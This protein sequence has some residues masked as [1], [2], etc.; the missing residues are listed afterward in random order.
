MSKYIILLVSILILSFP[1]FAA[2][3]IRINIAPKDIEYH[4]VNPSGLIT[5]YTPNGILNQNPEV[6][7]Y[8]QHAITAIE[9]PQNPYDE[10]HTIN[11]D[12]YPAYISPGKYNLVIYGAKVP[13]QTKIGIYFWWLNQGIKG[14]DYTAIHL[15]YPNVVW[16]YEF[17][18]TQNIPTYTQI[19]LIKLSTPADLIKDLTIAGQLGYIGN[20]HFVSDIIEN[21]NEIEKER[22]KP[23][24]KDDDHKLTPAQK[25]KKEYTELLSEIT[26]KYNKPE[27]DEY[28]KKEAY[29][30]LK[31]DL[32]YIINHIQ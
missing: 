17:E 6:D 11:Q 29:D 27:S 9:G 8:M 13:I 14:P 22:A 23:V 31:E 15:I 12:G 4:M 26:E 28:V 10:W 21:I 32:D 5:G 7:S 25:A 16:T 30:V 3:G 2:E 19:P 1:C 18:V 20:P 24:E